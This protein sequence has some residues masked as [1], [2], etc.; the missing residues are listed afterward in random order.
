M[1]LHPSPTAS[2][3]PDRPAPDAAPDALPP[4]AS[5]TRA[6]AP[7]TTAAQA[8]TLAI[9]TAIAFIALVLARAAEAAGAPPIAWR[10][11]YILAYV[12]GGYSGMVGGLAALRQGMLDVNILMIIAALGAAAL[13]DW[14]EG[15]V[16]L[17]LFSLSETLQTYA[18]GRTKG[19]VRAL[20]DLRPDQAT[21]REGEQLVTVPVENLV[22][23]DVVVVRP[24]E[25]LPADGRVARGTSDVDQATITGESVPVPKQPGDPVFAATINGTGVLD[26]EVTRRASESTVARIIDLVAEAQATRAPTQRLID[27]FGNRYAWAVI[28]GS[29]ATLVIP[30]AFLGWTFDEAF[31]RAMTLLVVASPC[32]L[33][34][35]TPASYLAGIANAARHRVLFKG[36]AFLEA[37]A[38]IDTVAIDKTGTLTHGRPA[39]TDIVTL[40]GRSEDELLALAAAVEGQ[41]EHLIA[42]AVVAGARERGLVFAEAVG[43]RALPGIGIEAWV[44]GELVQIAS[45]KQGQMGEGFEP[46]LLRLVETLEIQAKTAMVVSNGGPIGVLAV[47][48]TPRPAARATLAALRA[49]GVKRIA[50]VTGDNLHVAR[51]VAAEVGIAPEDVFAGLMPEEKVT[52]VERLMAEGRVAFVGDGVNDAPAL[53]SAALGI[54]MGAGGSDVALETADVVLMGDQIERLG[55]VFE[56]GR[57]ARRV[58]KQNIAFS[59]G[60]IV[61]LVLATLLRGIPLP[62]GVVAHEGSTVLVVL[63]GLR[64]LGFRG[65][66][67]RARDREERQAAEQAAD[68]TRDR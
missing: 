15:G 44:E 7:D 41:S 4:A 21:R 20:M 58:V 52:V 6:R 27:R 19:A 26:I 49:A 10:A 3:P 35:S 11:L 34:I 8:R 23:G 30:I 14:L 38:D 47:A 45:P 67:D 17:L 31:Y 48:D 40:D 18:L 60:V 5:A 61:V 2:P 51:A 37:A 54:A 39:L 25:R 55:Y 42:R 68:Q 28:L 65:S 46:E 59:V 1:T 50:M 66:L 56:L 16:L 36:G 53:A 12:T 62:L 22:P 43:A 24:G 64:L 13:G 29:L 33:V 32:A 57:A 9:L 63:N